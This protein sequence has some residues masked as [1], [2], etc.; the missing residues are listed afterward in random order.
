MDAERR[1]GSAGFLRDPAA[2]APVSV[3][4]A[5]RVPLPWS[6]PGVRAPPG[7]GWCGAGAALAR[8]YRWA[9]GPAL[10]AHLPAGLGGVAPGSPGTGVSRPAQ[11]CVVP[12]CG[13]KGA[14]SGRGVGSP[15]SDVAPHRPPP[16]FPP[17]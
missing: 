11:T 1:R 17:L 3:T 8:R 7:S 5:R 9:S 12:R 6:A 10:A 14:T 2:R 13:E 4:P 15:G 16:E